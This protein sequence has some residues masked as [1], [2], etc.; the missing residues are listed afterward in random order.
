MFPLPASSSSLPS[1]QSLLVLDNFYSRRLLMNT[2]LHYPFN[3]APSP[4]P[5]TG[6]TNDALDSTAENSFDV[7]MVVILAVLLCALVCALGLNS[8]I[9]C[10]LRFSSQVRREQAAARLANTGVKKKALRAFPTLDYSP[11]LNL[12]RL[13]SE[14]VICLSEFAQGERIRV[15]PKCNHGFHLKCIDKWLS[16][17]GSCPTCRECLLDTCQKIVGCPRDGSSDPQRIISPLDPEGAKER[18]LPSGYDLYHFRSIQNPSVARLS[19]QLV[20]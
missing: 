15:L 13:D 9:S 17:H 19:Q 8:I 14:C 6:A 5:G 2:P 7:N 16:N 12:P 20:C 3:G 4:I 1:F 18:R 11:G 10:A